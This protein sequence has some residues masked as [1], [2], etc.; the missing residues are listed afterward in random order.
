MLDNNLPSLIIG[1]PLAFGTTPVFPSVPRPCE[2]C[3]QPTWLDP[4]SRKIYEAGVKLVCVPC[5]GPLLEAEQPT[6][7]MMSWEGWRRLRNQN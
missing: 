1:N 2:T 3:G 7:H 5:A 6:E 4:W